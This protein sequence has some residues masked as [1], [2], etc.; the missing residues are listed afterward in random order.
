MTNADALSQQYTAFGPYRS[1][2]LLGLD[3][4]STPATP[5]AWPLA[6]DLSTYSGSLLVT[7]TYTVPE[8]SSLPLLGVACAATSLL[9]SRRRRQA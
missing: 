8:P 7:Y 4:F 9:V 6:D 5:G 1:G 3:V 2:G